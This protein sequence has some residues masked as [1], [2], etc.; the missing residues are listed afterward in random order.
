MLARRREGGREHAR[1]SGY[2]YIICMYT[3]T[4]LYTYMHMHIDM[5]LYRHV[6]YKHPHTARSRGVSRP[7]TPTARSRAC[8]P[9]AAPQSWRA[10]TRRPSADRGR[11]FMAVRA[12][13]F[14]EYP[15]TS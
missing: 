15:S 7:C 8:P 2:T 6:F 13:F 5:Y 9:R 3:Y 1:T 14:P 4:C 10:R 12:S 11:K